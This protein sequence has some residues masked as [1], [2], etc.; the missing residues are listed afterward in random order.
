MPRLGAEVVRLWPVRVLVISADR[1]YRAAAAMLLGRRGCPALTAAGEQEAIELAGREC[2]DVVVL[3]R[4]ASQERRSWDVPVHSLAASI[5]LAMARQG[6][7]VAPV[8]VVVVSD[9][10]AG[11]GRGGSSPHTFE[12]D[13]WGPFEELFRAIARADRARRLPRERRHLP[14][15]V[16]LREARAE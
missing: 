7:R 5:G 2:V 13:K 14:W 1:H 16:S 11:T 3:E 15:P 12:L 4:P 9:A 10:P 8:G 6:A